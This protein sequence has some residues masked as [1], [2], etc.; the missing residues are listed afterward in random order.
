MDTFKMMETL[1]IK[2]LTMEADATRSRRILFDV[3]VEIA[4]ELRTF[5]GALE[6]KFPEGWNERQKVALMMDAVVMS[7]FLVWCARRRGYFVIVRNDHYHF[8]E[9]ADLAETYRLR[10]PEVEI[11]TPI[12]ERTRNQHQMSGRID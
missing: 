12:G 10:F 3:P 5:L 4:E 7:R 11:M 8:F 1:G 9:D 2:H 6:L